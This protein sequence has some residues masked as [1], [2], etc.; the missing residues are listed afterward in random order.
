MLYIISLKILVMS[1]KC[2][3]GRVIKLWCFSSTRVVRDG[4]GMES[5]LM[6]SLG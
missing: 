4:L 6:N 2:L 1:V 3:T 5:R